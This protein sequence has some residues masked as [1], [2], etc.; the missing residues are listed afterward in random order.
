MM[1]IAGGL[2][3]GDEVLVGD[4][5]YPVS[6]YSLRCEPGGAKSGSVFTLKPRG[7]FEPCLGYRIDWSEIANHRRP[8]VAQ[9]QCGDWMGDFEAGNAAY[10]VSFA[11]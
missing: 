10:A 4:D 5:W 3:R 2:Q 8:I 1:D 9:Q 11:R 7:V 6:G